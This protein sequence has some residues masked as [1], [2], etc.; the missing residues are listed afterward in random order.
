MQIITSSIRSP[1]GWHFRPDTNPPRDKMQVE[2]LDPT[3]YTVC[4]SV[5]ISASQKG[6]LKDGS[7][8]FVP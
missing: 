8:T 4:A 5:R 6:Q 1:K 7:A 2:D 3:G